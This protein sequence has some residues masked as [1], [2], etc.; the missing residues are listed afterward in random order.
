MIAKIDCNRAGSIQRLRC[1]VGG[2]VSGSAAPGGRE[3]LHNDGGLI[4]LEYQC[5]V[6]RLKQQ[7][8]LQAGACPLTVG[9]SSARSS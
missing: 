4:G 9:I 5:H 1:P 8:K 7:Q 2:R 3:S 6:G